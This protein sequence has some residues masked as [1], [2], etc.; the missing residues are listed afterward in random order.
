M[1][2][3]YKKFMLCCDLTHTHLRCCLF[4]AIRVQG[5][6]DVDS[7]VV[8][9]LDNCLIPFLVLIAQVLGQKNEQ[10]PSDSFIAMHI[11]NVFKFRLTTSWPSVFLESCSNLIKSQLF[12]LMCSWFFQWILYVNQWAKFLFT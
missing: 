8:D 2:K 11:P 12:P 5:R 10:L 6:H 9:Q 3:P 1:Y 7:G 4:K